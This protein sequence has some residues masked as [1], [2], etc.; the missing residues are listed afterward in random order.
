MSQKLPSQFNILIVEDDRGLNDQLSEMIQ[1]AGYQVNTCFDGHTALLKATKHQPQL[2]LLDLMLPEM[3]GISLLKILRKT[4]QV[5]V[6]ILTAKGA[7]EERITGL[8]HGADDY[9]A[10]P[11]NQTELLLRIEA[12][13]R[14]SQ[15]AQTE[16]VDHA[17]IDNLLLDLNTQQVFAGDSPIEFTAIQFKLLWELAIHRGEVLSKAYLSQQVLNR[18]LGA[19][20]RSLDMH[21]SRVRRKLTCVGWRGDRLQTVHGKG[22]CLK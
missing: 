9:V 5:P 12:L 4:S 14:R 19:Y 13:L 18:T 8:R 2:I 21:L 17:E 16:N 6:I 7:E 10:K 22:Y 11:F 15:P 3:D 1:D 20:D